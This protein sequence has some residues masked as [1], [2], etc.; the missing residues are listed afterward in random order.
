MNAVTPISAARS[1]Q[2]KIIIKLKKEFGP[3]ILEALEDPCVTDIE[4]NSDGL[5]FVD[6][7]DAEHRNE[8]TKLSA[9]AR[10]AIVKTVAASLNEVVTVEHPIVG[11]ELPILGA[12]FEGAIPPVSIPGPSFCIRKKAV[13]IMSLQ[14]YLKDGIITPQIYELLDDAV[15][16]RQNLLV[17]G[18]TGTGKTTFINAYINQISE[19]CP[20]DRLL[21]CEDVRE[22]QSSVQ[23][24]NTMI[25]TKHC[26]LKDII[27]SSLR[28]HPDR[29]LIG[30]IRDADQAKEAF[31]G[32]NTGHKGGIF[33]I[34]ANSGLDTIQRLEAFCLTNDGHRNPRLIVRILDKILFMKKEGGQ[35][36]VKEFYELKDY[37]DG[38]YNLVDLITNKEIQLITT[39]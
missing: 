10:E 14:D 12:R 3:I 1:I 13:K 16:K 4:V 19:R 26:S 35:R 7:V 5:V 11:G 21:I 37:S 9:S 27:H 34:H 15:I 29:L 22:I 6:R 2:N 39:E 20:H 31:K 30:E 33:S 23:N 24:T 18:S 38:H 36:K 25:A 17:A 28:Q 8:L 32:W